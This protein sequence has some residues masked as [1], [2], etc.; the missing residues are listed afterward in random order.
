MTSGGGANAGLRRTTTKRRRRRATEKQA[1]KSA[2]MNHLT[3]A[4]A[5]IA[6]LQFGKWN[7][8]ILTSLYAGTHTHTWVCVCV[9]RTSVDCGRWQVKY[10][11]VDGEN[12]SDKNWRFFQRGKSTGCFFATAVCA[13][14]SAVYTWTCTR[15]IGSNRH[16]VFRFKLLKVKWFGISRIAKIEMSFE[17]LLKLSRWA[18]LSKSRPYDFAD[19]LHFPYTSIMFLAFV[20]LI[21]IKQYAHK[22]SFL[23]TSNKL[24]IFQFFLTFPLSRVLTFLKLNCT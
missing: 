15:W 20:C 12:F 1:L 3:S 16:V 9:H 7:A 21:W 22:V 13:T 11:K 23:R 19:T 6:F 14:R 5:A 8:D 2:T 17:T 24:F 4:K 18:H 10:L